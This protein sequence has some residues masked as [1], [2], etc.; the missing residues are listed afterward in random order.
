MKKKVG[1]NKLSLSDKIKYIIF[2][3]LIGI[4]LVGIILIVLNLK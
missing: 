4:A 1:W 2:F 3:I